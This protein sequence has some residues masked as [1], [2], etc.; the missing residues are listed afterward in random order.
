M[1]SIMGED[2][3]YSLMDYLF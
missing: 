1:T 2:K 3:K